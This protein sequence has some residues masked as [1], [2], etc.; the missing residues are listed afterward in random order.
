MAD[1]P[2]YVARYMCSLDNP[3]ATQTWLLL[4]RATGLPVMDRNGIRLFDKAD[5][6]AAMARL[7]RPDMPA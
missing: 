5:A 1:R 4:D 7:N 6:Q 2:R 3:D